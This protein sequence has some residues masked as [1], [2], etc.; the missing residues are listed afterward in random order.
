MATK[1]IHQLRSK[2]NDD[3]AGQFGPSTVD[4]DKLCELYE[5]EISKLKSENLKL[6]HGVDLKIVGLND[7]E[8]MA[9]RIWL[10]RAIREETNP[11]LAKSMSSVVEKLGGPYY[12]SWK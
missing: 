12:T 7:K 10:P 9:L 6:K 11:E 4:V 8:D 1:K 2:I 5:E 3:G